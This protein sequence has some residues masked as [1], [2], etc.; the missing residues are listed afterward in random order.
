MTA[1]TPIQGANSRHMTRLDAP[2]PCQLW[3]IDLNAGDSAPVLPAL[4]TPSTLSADEVARAG[5]FVF[6]KDRAHY[7]T[8]R[9]AL[10][11]V[12]SVHTGEDAAS[13]RFAYG[14]HGKPHLRDH[15]YCGF[16]LSHSQGVALIAI[17]D[18]GTVGVDVEVVRA[19]PDAR[20]LAQQYFRPDE[21]ALLDALEP[22]GVDAAFLRGWTR[23]E[24]CLK[25]VGTGL[26]APQLPAT[27]LGLDARTLRLS[28]EPDDV[29]VD[30]RS[31]DLCAV[32]AIA[33][34]AVLISPAATTRAASQPSRGVHA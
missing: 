3:L 1:L 6:A 8:A 15:P 7:V 28:G 17:L 24:A 5:R 20:T 34:L 4:S 22:P 14:P 32:G 31:F 16:N 9:S 27:G 23:K 30:L 21:C 18:P 11:Q 13:L 33:S 29:E 2:G 12:L 19:V 25:A 10:R 26:A